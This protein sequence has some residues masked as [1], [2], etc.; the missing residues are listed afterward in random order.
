MLD[1][2][3]SLEELKLLKL[4]LLSLKLEEDSSLEKLE[5]ELPSLELELLSLKLEEES[6]L[7]ELSLELLSL[8]LD[9]DV[10]LEEL[11]SSTPTSLRTKLVPL[12][13]RLGKTRFCHVVEACQTHP[14]SIAEC[15]GEEAV[16]S[17]I[18]SITAS[19]M[20]DDV[21]NNVRMMEEKTKLNSPY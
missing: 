5:L 13:A 21:K 1:D 11:S 6:P 16:V 19:A 14:T 4:E 20:A 9:E 15:P 12:R 2:D 8:R 17:A 3:A 7:E 10:S 18:L